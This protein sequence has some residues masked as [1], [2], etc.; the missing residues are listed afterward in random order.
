MVRGAPLRRRSL[1]IG[2]V[3][4]DVANKIEE[5]RKSCP[6][7]VG[8][9]TKSRIAPGEGTVR[10]SRLSRRENTP[11][12]RAPRLRRLPAIGVRSPALP[13]SRRSARM[14]WGRRH[15]LRGALRLPPGADQQVLKTD[16]PDFSTTV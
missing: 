1:Y 9:L 8:G 11:N 14:P 10:A 12:F 13:G 3:D 7:A 5:T 16:D 2:M 15:L 4:D 6:W